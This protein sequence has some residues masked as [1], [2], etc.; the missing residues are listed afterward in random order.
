VTR[1]VN[2]YKENYDIYAGRGSIF[3]NPFVIGK[4]GDR[5]EVVEKFRV[6][7]YDRIKNDESFRLSVL[8]LKGKIL[9]C[10]C[11]PKSCHCDIIVE[12]LEGGADE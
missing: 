9:G 1:V 7:F 8:Q 5:G 10:F 11:K 2:K 6:Y 12:Y 3:G 4:D